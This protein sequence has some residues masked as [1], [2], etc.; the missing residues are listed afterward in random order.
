M[1]E[2]TDEEIIQ[3][4]RKAASELYTLS[5]ELQKQTLYV[6]AADR[7]ELILKRT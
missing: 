4:L 7:I 1:P 3:L 5:P 6:I 2:Y